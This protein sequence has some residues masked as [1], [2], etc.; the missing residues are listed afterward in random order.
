[1]A[2]DEARGEL[3]ARAAE[4]SS[5]LVEKTYA[6]RIVLTFGIVCGVVNVVLYQPE[7]PHNTG[8]IARSC[9]LFGARLHLIEPLGFPYP[10]RDLRRSSM[11]YVMQAAPV[12]HVSWAAFT[13]A[14]EE[15]AKLWLFSDAGETSYTDAPFQTNDYLVFGRESDGLPAAI[16]SAYERLSIPMPGAKNGA[17]DD[18]RFHSLNVSV[19][20]G[21]ALGE[22]LRQLNFP[23]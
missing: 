18:H 11:D 22:A 20:V 15:S 14:L 23:R 5:G 7:N 4:F 6:S 12:L 2:K 1:M 3:A 19:S 17:R 8:G 10:S 21:I 9:A 16:L 13:A